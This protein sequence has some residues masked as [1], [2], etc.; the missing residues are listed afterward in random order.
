MKIINVE[1]Y[2]RALIYI[3]NGMTQMKCIKLL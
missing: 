2:K 3:Y 1:T